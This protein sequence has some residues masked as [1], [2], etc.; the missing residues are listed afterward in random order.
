MNGMTFSGSGTVALS[1]TSITLSG[2]GT[3]GTAGTSG[4]TVTFGTATCLFNVIVIAGASIDWKFNQGATLYQGS[5]DNA[6]LTA[7]GPFTTYSYIG[8]NANETLIFSLIDLAGGIGIES[9]NSA[10][11]TGNN[12]AFIFNFTGGDIWT[13]D[14]SIAGTSVIFTVTSHNTTTKTISGNF[15]GT[16]KDASNNVR[17]I[18]SGTFSGTYP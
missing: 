2:S 7:V 5:T 4:V 12:A 17:T 1:T 9:Y 14:P 13:A 15:S 8:S 11:S 6:S 16:V 10:S 3:P 18:T